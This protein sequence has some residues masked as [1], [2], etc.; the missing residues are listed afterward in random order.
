MSIDLETLTVA[1]IAS[2]LKECRFSA[3][4]LILACIQRI[5]AFNPI[6]NAMIFENRSALDEA[7]AIDRKRAEGELLPPLAGVPLVVKDTMDMAGYPT[8]GGWHLLCSQ[9][10]GIDLIPERDCPAVARLRKAGCIILGKTNV[11]ILS[12]T[13]THADNSWAGPTINSAFL[14]GVPGGSSAGSASAV[15]AGFAVLGLAEETGG[16]IQNPASAHGLVGVK[17]TFGLVPNVGVM[18]LGANTLDVIGPITRTVRDAALMLDALAGPC[19]D[20]PK[21]KDIG[22]YLPEGGYAASLTETALKGARLGLY[23]EGWRKNSGGWRSMPLHPDIVSAYQRAQGEIVK[24]GAVLIDDP[25]AG[26]GFADIAETVGGVDDFDM[27][28]MEPLAYDLQIYLKNLGPKAALKT[29]DEF[30][31]ATQS[32]NPFSSTGVLSYLG[33]SPEFLENCKSPD[34]APDL[35]GFM[36]VRKAYVDILMRVFAEQNLDALVFP[37]MADPLPKRGSDNYIRETTVCEINIGGMP[38][39]TV[40]AG[41]LEDGS[42]FNLVFVGKPFSEVTLLSLALHYEQATLHRKTPTLKSAF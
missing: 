39:V 32:E 9:T 25:M 11:P 8:T 12:A 40:P 28:G 23:G 15:A 20:D 35:S 2:A 42:P 3:E 16:S 5:A 29:F 6:Y 13:G 31:E 27:R 17:P 14:D 37:Q 7:R 38:V 24:L 19:D 4:D 33:Q 10:G 34:K 18:P 22:P 1:D 36:A 30:A 21:T 41:Y 26:S